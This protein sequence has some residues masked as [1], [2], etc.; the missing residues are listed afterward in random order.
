MGLTKQYLRYSPSAVFGIIGSAR[1]GICN[2]PKQK[3]LIATA[4]SENVIIWNTK[5]GEK[6]ATLGAEKHEVTA[7][8]A[9][10]DGS[11]LAVGYN[12]GSIRI[13]DE[14]SGECTVTLNGHKSA[15][16]CIAYDFEGH[17]M[18]SG[19]R[20]TC[21]IIWDVINQA[22]L[23][24]LQG[25]KGPVTN[26]AFMRSRSN[27][28]VS[29]SKDTFLKFWDLNVQHCFKTLTGHLSEVWDFSLIKND[30][31]VVTGTNDSE[32][33]IWKLEFKDDLQNESLKTEAIDKIQP[34]FKK[35]KIRD[36]DTEDIDSDNED[37]FDAGILKIERMGSVLRAG[38]DKLS[39]IV[40][41]Q[42]GNRLLACHGTAD[43][44]V[45]LFLVCNEEELKKRMRRK[46][47]KERKR[48][49]A[50][51]GDANL[52]VEE[53]NDNIEPTIQEEFRRLKVIRCSGKVRNIHIDMDNEKNEAHLLLSLANNQVEQY[54]ISLDESAK[55]NEAE[56]VKSFDHAGH[57]SDV[58]SVAVSSD[59]TAILSAS[60]EAIKI[61]SRSTQ[62]CIRTIK[63]GYGLCS[64]FV[65][66][67]RH[68][69]IGT[70]E[71]KIQIFD[72]GS[73]TMTEEVQ[74][75]DKEIWS[76]HMSQDQRG[77][78]TASGDQSVK[79]WKFELITKENPETGEAE[80]KQLSVIHTR[81]L[82]LEED[83]LAVRLSSD[84]R[85]VAVS[86]LDSTIK[87]F[88]V[89]TFKFFLS[90]YGHKLPALALDIS[91]DNTLAV[92]GSADKNIKI[93]GLDFGDCHKS[94]FAH[95]DNITGLQ[96]IPNTHMFFTI[97]KDGMLKQWDADNFQRILTLEAHHGEIWS[98]ALSPNGKYVITSGHDKTLRLWEKTQEPLILEDERETE[99]EKQED[100]Q[101]AT[102]EG[103]LVPGE[104]DKEAGMPSK[105]TAETEKGAERLMEAI[106][107]YYNYKEEKT[108]CSEKDQPPLPMLMSAYP[109]VENEDDF[110]AE[111]VGR[112]KSS[113]LEE[114]LLVLPLDIVINLI[115]ILNVL[116]EKNIKSET[117]S[118]IFF[119]LIEIH[120]GP[121]SASSSEVKKI[122]KDVRIKVAKRLDDLKDTVG[123]NLAAMHFVQNQRSERERVESYVD[124]TSKFKEKRRKRK[125][126]QKTIQTAI[127]TI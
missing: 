26:V 32:L 76:M 106:E 86:L 119:F 66:G 122:I 80:G 44:N 43:K 48:K 118:R 64:F 123:L 37:E 90:L 82:K 83:A 121:L 102:G 89:D 87:V 11:F 75:H 113:E 55:D 14:K 34:V 95:D 54:K 104:Q 116:L 108:N 21:V 16:T 79:F 22:G 111:I 67:D 96:F 18:V 63:S 36:D 42:F 60:H 15:V 53:S 88:F 56:K 81:T 35:I 127:I 115:K 93:W 50:E 19:S 103:R 68:A 23:Y 25:H 125:Q 17:R 47:K 27:V 51:V 105:K 72:I 97:G 2:I 62:N 58:R 39:H 124:A 70:K 99:R 110:M 94:I 77:F 73:A 107:V 49:V 8:C 98:L 59:N 101:L 71:G 41:D 12:N 6:V 46:A 126:K 24:R 114:T 91:T 7:L 84:G 5:T 4:C 112:I 65:P 52:I 3:H 109:D 10:K 61:W 30:K 33:R 92:T 78:V 100:E 57:R 20:D 28:V 120:F 85:L 45:E 9:N 1:G 40:A 74:A 31:Y 13:F 69:I 117:M 38:Q 29:S